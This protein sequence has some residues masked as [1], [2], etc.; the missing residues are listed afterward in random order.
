MFVYKHFFDRFQ[1]MALSLML[2]AFLYA[3]VLA[4]SEVCPAVDASRLTLA[5]AAERALCLN[6][7]A[8]KAAA[9]T[10]ESQAAVQQA[11]AGRVPVWTANTNPSWIWQRAD[12]SNNQTQRAGASVEG[13]YTLSDGGARQARVL[14]NQQNLKGNEQ[15]QT[16]V[17]Q[18][19]LREF[20]GQWA[21]VR[22]AQATVLAREAALASSKASESASRARLEAGS[23][24]RVDL[25]SAQSSLAQTQLDLLS[26]QTDFRK[27]MGVLA[28]TLSLNPQMSIGLNGDDL[29]MLDTSAFTAT[30]TPQALTELLRQEHPR[31]KAQQASVESAKA[32]LE[33]SRAE[34]K[35]Q[36]SLTG[37][38]GPTWSRNNSTGSYQSGTQWSGQVGLNWSKTFS[39]GGSRDAT[40]AR[41]LAQLEAA[42]ATYQEI[43]RSLSTTLWQS[44]AEWSDADA[45]VAASRLALDAAIASEAAQSGRY[46]A[47]L[48]TINDVLTAQSQLAQ[49]RQQL[50]TSE[51][52]RLRATAALLHS[53]G[54]LDVSFSS[55]KP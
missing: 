6:P 10:R 43:E 13:S 44:Y 1:Q 45:S 49:A 17:R 16:V 38:A 9:N 35:P 30:S 55:A 40:I 24:T 2:C 28:Q 34:G 11:I 20:V 51:Q 29:K 41:S 33:I 25:L 4:Q 52:S 12:G 15:Q 23:A 42:S 54:Q 32:A 47:G 48:G 53:I 22:D 27:A 36:L 3:N 46:R 31:L 39:D 7:T 37:S 5:S 50:A 14:Q 8:L 21:D 18:D 19:A 26:A